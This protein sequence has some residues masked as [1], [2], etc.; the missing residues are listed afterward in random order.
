[1]WLPGIWSKMGPIHAQTLHRGI[2]GKDLLAVPLMW[3]IRI[4][5]LRCVTFFFFV[6]YQICLLLLQWWQKQRLFF[7]TLAWGGGDSSQKYY[8]NHF[9]QDSVLQT[10]IKEVYA[11]FTD[12]TEY[13]GPFLLKIYLQVFSLQTFYIFRKHRCLKKI[14]SVLLP[15]NSVPSDSIWPKKSFR[16]NQS[17][18]QNLPWFHFGLDF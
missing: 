14:F 6:C 11:V 18:V 3:R 5:T 9:T 16:K 10:F 2:T 1:M 7:L 8:A 12:Y 13:T 17:T 15:W 4:S